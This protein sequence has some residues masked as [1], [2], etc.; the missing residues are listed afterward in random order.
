ML[1]LALVSLTPVA[2]ATPPDQTWLP[3]LYDDADYDDVVLLI[4]SS[5]GIAHLCL[6]DDARPI[7]RAVVLL[8][9]TYEERT[10]LARSGG[11]STRAPPAPLQLLFA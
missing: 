10:P 8:S 6:L 9:P 1:A 7:L 5:S 11:R 2:F 3:G 4:T